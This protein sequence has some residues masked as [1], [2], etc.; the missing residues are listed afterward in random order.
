LRGVGL[1]CGAHVVGVDEIGERML[2]QLRI[3]YPKVSSNIGF[4]RTK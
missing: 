3:E 2:E 1:L 4:T